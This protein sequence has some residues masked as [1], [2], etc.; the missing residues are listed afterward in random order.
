MI[1]LEFGLFG[2]HLL[3]LYHVNLG[4]GWWV[5]ISSAKIDQ[6]LHSDGW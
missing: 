3:D 1:N 2:M 5:Q 6:W 4:T